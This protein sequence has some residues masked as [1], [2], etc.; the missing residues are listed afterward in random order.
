MKK[1]NLFTLCLIAA[2]GGLL[3]GYDFGVIGT[4]EPFYIK[5]EV[6]DLAAKGREWWRGFAMASAVLGCIFGAV[7]LMPLPDRWGRKPSL[8]LA[9]AL[10]TLSAIW[11]MFA[12]SFWSFVGARALGG[13]G[14]GLASNVSPVYIAEISPPEK[15]GS[16][17][18]VNQ[19]TIASGIGIAQLV[20]FLIDKYL[21]GD[22]WGWRIMFGAEAIPAL[23]FF[24]LALVMPESP[25][26]LASRQ[27]SAAKP[28][29]NWFDGFNRHVVG[30][31]AIG[32]FLAAYQQW[33]GFNIL[34]NFPKDVFGDAGYGVSA[35][36]F[37]QVIVGGVNFLLTIAAIL[38]VDRWGRRPLMLLGAGGIAV[39][40]AILGTMYHNGVTGMPI[41]ACVLVVCACFS[42][43]L[44]PI[45]WVLLSELFPTRVRGTAMSICVATLWTGTFTLQQ[46][47]PPIRKAMGMDGAF[48][49]YAAICVA[50][51]VVIAV[52]LRETK[53]RALEQ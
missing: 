22:G 1:F 6:F 41:V 15:R 52:F 39:L 42:L 49:L 36:L 26:W 19:L 7:V 24:C 5:P 44:G 14:V 13:I 25:M 32:V 10:F 53:G 16:L 46:T 45:T 38:L 2:M 50:A 8:V 40:Y 20:N 29:R 35:V 37:N 31:V 9:A 18:A 17:V 4:A 12:F 30:L 11:T 27:A 51:V 28:S 23:A 21:G 48:W 33:C 47:F 3:F 43:T 34:L